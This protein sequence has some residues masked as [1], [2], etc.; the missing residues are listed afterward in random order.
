MPEIVCPSCGA[1]FKIEEMDYEGEV[2]CPSCKALLHVI[3]SEGVVEEVE[4]IEEGFEEESWL[5]DED[6][7]ET[8]EEEEEDWGLAE[9]DFWE[10][11]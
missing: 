8:E 1:H 4:L 11:E 6:L 9:E 7:W 5:E 10:E 2:S 3:I